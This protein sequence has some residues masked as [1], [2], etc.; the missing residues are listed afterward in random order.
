MCDLQVEEQSVEKVARVSPARTSWT[1][2][3]PAST[4]WTRVSPVIPLLV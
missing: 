1:R 3:S 4:S 2:V